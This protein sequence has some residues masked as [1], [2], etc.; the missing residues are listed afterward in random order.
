MT[1]LGDKI[2]SVIKNSFDM[3]LNANNSWTTFNMLLDS[4]L[5]ITESKSGI[6]GQVDTINNTL[7][8]LAITNVSWNSSLS[9]SIKSIRFTLKKRNLMSEAILT[10]SVICTDNAMKEEAYYGLPEGHPK[11]ITFLSIPLIEN[12]NAIGVIMLANRK[13]SYNSDIIKAIQLNSNYLISLINIYKTV[14]SSFE[15]NLFDLDSK[16]IDIIQDG[17]IVVNKFNKI[18]ICNKSAMILFNVSDPINKNLS[19]VIP[20]FNE[21]MLNNYNNKNK[22][23]IENND[24]DKN[25]KNKILELTINKTSIYGADIYVILIHEQALYDSNSINKKDKYIKFINREIKTPLQSIILSISLLKETINKK[26]NKKLIDKYIT[27]IDKST[28]IMYELLNDI[29]SL[30]EIIQGNIN[31]NISKIKLSTIIEN[32]LTQLNTIIQNKKI[33]FQCTHTNF[34]MDTDP[35]I[36]EK[37]LKCLITNS[38]RQ[39]QEGYVKIDVIKTNN[40]LKITILDNGLGYDTNE[41][42]DFNNNIYETTNI[43]DTLLNYNIGSSCMNIAIAKKLTELLNGTLSIT[44]EKDRGS[45]YTLSFDLNNIKNNKILNNNILI[46]DDNKTNIDIL[47]ILIEEI[48]LL[49]GWHLYVTCVY[50]GYECYHEIK[51]NH[52]DLIFLSINMECL[53][54]YEIA[55]YLRNESQYKDI[56]ISISEDI[57]LDNLKYKPLKKISL[58][59]Y[60][61]K[62]PI[63]ITDVEFCITKFLT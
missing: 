21:I 18:I 55:N 45:L 59:N 61:L 23:I 35:I 44:S 3:Y 48:N 42:T 31:I 36:M 17:I 12:N 25:E 10:K 40:I 51:N 62:K 32:I 8:P 34:E 54:G 38:L 37:I 41:L 5:V 53:D 52:Y 22:I 30:D 13:D 56:I 2:N 9:D 27:I 63:F 50:S 19:N 39:S 57:D 43:S 11:L 6:I 49:H 60:N 46:V 15:T 29:R 20:Y 47:K 58:F 26:I 16:I 28:K 4:L 1:D 33:Y 7:I 14:T 24:I